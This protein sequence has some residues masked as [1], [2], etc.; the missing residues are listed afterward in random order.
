MHF[1]S[2]YSI[3]MLFTHFLCFLTCK[4]AHVFCLLQEECLEN[5]QDLI[6]EMFPSLRRSLE[7]SQASVLSNT[8]GRIQAPFRRL[9][10][11]L[12]WSNQSDKLDDSLIKVT[13]RKALVVDGATLEFAFK[14][15]CKDLFVT[16]AKEC[17]SVICCRAT[18]LKKVHV[19]VYVT[20]TCMSYVEHF[21]MYCS[22]LS[23]FLLL[24]Y[25]Y[26]HVC[27]YLT[28]NFT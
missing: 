10:S 25:L 22:C 15:R 12:S 2:F 24:C 17:Y 28:A 11:T 18:P 16:V 13:S 27:K 6:T 3:F 26:I 19:H 5:L 7:A 4:V 1:R 21:F 20:Y 8:V 14:P 9:Q 23:L